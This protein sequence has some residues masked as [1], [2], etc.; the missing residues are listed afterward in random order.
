[1]AGRLARLGWD[2][3]LIARSAD[4]LATTAREVRSAGRRE[5]AVVGD[6]SRPGDIEAVCSAVEEG[7]GPVS[8]L[9]NN[10][11]VSGEHARTFRSDPDEWWRA[12]EINLRGPFML[13][14]RLVPA[15]VERGRGYVIN[16]NSLDC[17]RAADAGSP[18]YGVSKT[19]LRRLTEILAAELLGTG[20]IA[21]DL[22][23]GMVR[24]AMGGARPD[25][26]QMPPEAWLEPSAA[27]DSVEQI[28]SGRYDGLHGRFLHAVD[29]LDAV[30]ATIERL[31][32]AR[33][34]RLLPAGD[35][36]PVL[37]YGATTSHQETR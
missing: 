16:I 5:V 28:L 13:T 11:A 8:V 19:A 29:D 24:T 3:G 31:P 35:D 37:S 32:E 2:V 25:A 34:L 4:E 10:A 12:M 27:A 33:L 1:L 22:S 26:D 36:D 23:P 6:V 20:V 9:I 18:V 17:S 7:L 15:M 14:R 21:V 30:L